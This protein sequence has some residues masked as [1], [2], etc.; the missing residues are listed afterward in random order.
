MTIY[1]NDV[2]KLNKKADNACP[3]ELVSINI[4]YLCPQIKDIQRFNEDI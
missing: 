2:A 4:T 1:T 3:K